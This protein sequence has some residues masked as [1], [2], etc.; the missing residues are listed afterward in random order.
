MAN[1]SFSVNPA[2]AVG[3]LSRA[4]RAEGHSEAGVQARAAAR[5]AKWQAVIDGLGNGL[6]EVGSRTPVAGMPAWVTLEVVTGGF[7]TGQFAAGGVLMDYE[8]ALLDRLG[9]SGAHRT[10]LALNRFYLTEAGQGALHR[11]LENGCYRVTVPEEGALLTVAWLAAHGQL[12]RAFDVLESIAPFFDRLRFY[13]PPDARPILPSS[14]VFRQSVKETIAAV[15]S[16][17]QQIHVARMKEVIEVWLPLYDRVVSMFLE[18]MVAGWPCQTY[19]ETWPQRARALLADYETLRV[20]H[21]LSEK[22][23][24]KRSQFARLREALEKCATSPTALT[25][26][27]VGAIRIMLEAFV[28][29]YGTPGSEQ[30]LALR[31]HQ[32]ATVAAPLHVDLRKVMV[33]RLAAA[34]ADSG[35]ESL[36]VVGAPVTEAEARQFNVAIGASMPDSVR[37]KVER[38]LV[39]PIETLV[40]K[41]II[42]SGEVLARVVPQITSQVRAAGLEDAQLRLLSAA[43]YVA[44]RKRR[45]LLLI[46]YASQVKLSELPWAQ[47]IQANRKGSLGGEAEAR[48][49]FTQLASIAF[50]A[51]PHQIVPNKLLTEFRTLAQL[52]SMVDLPFV[53]ELA[54]DIF[55]GGFSSKFL[56]AAQ[57]SARLLEGSLYER[58]YGYAAVEVL[59]IDDV[60]P[61]PRGKGPGHSERFNR[62]CRE[63]S[64]PDVPGSVAGNGKVI[65]QA[66]VLTTQNLGPVF[67][68]LGLQTSLRARLPELAQRC[69]AWVCQQ[70]AI[71]TTEYRSLLRRVKNCAYAWRQMIFYLS[72]VDGRELNA[73]LDFAQS[74]LATTRVDVQRRLRPGIDGLVLVAKG[75]RFET[76]THGERRLLGWTTD[77]HWLLGPDT[78]A[79]P[80]R[81]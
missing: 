48:Q 54:A 25:G 12:D 74:H 43:I 69:F 55:M 81:R 2:Y 78:R 31:A 56:R 77:R 75:G 76:A 23:D 49:V 14:L 47:A 58:Y 9:F 52:A 37:R 19:S 73:F 67:D 17:T 13:P 7:A 59:Q 11:L 5:I 51:F 66:Q 60:K 8:E 57:I 50:T 29:R 40:E 27:Q 20:T 15:N 65:E 36:D 4:L 22:P 80:I 53:D 21:Q 45:S 79:P 32:R 38:S 1:E 6:L 72:F 33:G 71:K 68:A 41:K 44:F 46:D 16:T 30:H 10:R 61:L 63:R 28:R 39:A 42:C 70:Q 35:L 62:L 64:G 26:K 24:K 18:T 3:Q 34:P